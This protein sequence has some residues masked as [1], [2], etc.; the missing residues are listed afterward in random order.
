MYESLNEGKI[1]LKKEENLPFLGFQIHPHPLVVCITILMSR[2]VEIFYRKKDTLPLQVIVFPS[3][4][5]RE[6]CKWENKEI[7]TP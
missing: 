5:T 2:K 7:L 3:S 4:H 6:Y 1:E